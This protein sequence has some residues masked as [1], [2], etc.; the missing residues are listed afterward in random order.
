MKNKIISKSD[1]AEEITFVVYYVAFYFFKIMFQK[2]DK[3]KYFQ[4]HPSLSH[5]HSADHKNIKYH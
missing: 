5:N 3:R 4:L 1:K 2:R